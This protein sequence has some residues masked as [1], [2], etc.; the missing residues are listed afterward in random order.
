MRSGGKIAC[1]FALSFLMSCKSERQKVGP[2]VSLKTILLHDV[3]GLFGGCALWVGE[4]RTAFIQ[5]VDRPPTGASGVWEKRYKKKLTDDHWAAI[6]RLVGAHN[7]LTVKMPERLGVPDEARP[8]IIFL[9]R[10]GT[11]VKLRKWIND[12]HPD[13]DPVYTYLLGICQ[14]QGELLQEGQY[15]WEWCPTGFE[16]PW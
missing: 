9:T 14:D 16:Q 6:E 5:V 4:D 11:T 8:I 12:K 13:F 10:S 3:Q 1:L 15:M 7:L 2:P